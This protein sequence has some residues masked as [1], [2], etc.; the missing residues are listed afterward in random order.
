MSHLLRNKI[1]PFFLFRRV[2]QSAQMPPKRKA[3]AEADAAAAP[4]RST[5]ARTSTSRAWPS[6]PA[7]AVPKP[8]KVSKAAAAK[9]E[10]GS[11][12]AATVKS[13]KDSK[14]A[15]VKLESK[16]S[17]SN[18]AAATAA[19]AAT[20]VDDGEEKVTERQY[21][22]LKAEPETRLEKGVDVSFSI[23]DLAAKTVPEPWDGVSPPAPFSG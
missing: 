15:P 5:R 4:R 6:P 14:A 9:P 20:H 17:D 18:G 23:D 10:G 2:H 16:G 12:A 7:T 1:S 3:P 21:W 11:K 8:K 22:L 13:R 19:P